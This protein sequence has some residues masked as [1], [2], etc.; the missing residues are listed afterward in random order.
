MNQDLL[1]ES[2][3]APGVARLTLN[4]PDRRNALDEALIDALRDGVARHAEHAA[5]R[6]ILIAAAGTAFCA[7]ADLRGMIERGLGDSDRNVHDAERL[8]ALLLAIRDCPKPVVALVQGPAFGGG[9]GL[10]ACCD[11]TIAADAA[12]FR[13]PEVQLG[14]VPAVISPYVVEAIG[15]RHARRLF[16]T[17]ETIDAAR[18]RELGLV[19]EVVGP[20]ALEARGLELAAAIAQGGPL[21]LAA[22]KRLIASVAGVRPDAELAQR[23]ARLLADLRAGAEAQE[24]LS[25]A[26]EKRTPAWRQ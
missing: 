15:A 19:H 26:L 20:D 9:V 7:G 4:R 25:A 14:I 10:A 5:T 18:A 24:G 16:L 23:T 12:R 8:A 22:C 11:V 1:L 6:V 2:M 21:A 17:G 3:P 13:L